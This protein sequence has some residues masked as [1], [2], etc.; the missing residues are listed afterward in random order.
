MVLLGLFQFTNENHN[1]EDKIAIQGKYKF[2]LLLLAICF[3][4]FYA[5]FKYT[6]FF[7]CSQY[8][9][10]YVVKGLGKLLLFASILDAKYNTSISLV[11]HLK[12]N[13]LTRIRN[14]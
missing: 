7:V 8:R 9:S 10:Y 13:L 6:I 4:P 14:S 2:F 3:A 1:L 12:F 5:V 11:Q